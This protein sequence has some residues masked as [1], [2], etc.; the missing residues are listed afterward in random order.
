M[1]WWPTRAAEATPPVITL[2]TDYGSG[3]LYVGLLHGVIE[4]IAPGA[5]VIDLTHQLPLG[6][7]LGGALALA[8]ALPY[9]PVGIH[10]AV[11]DPGVGTDRRAVALRC[12]DGRILIGPDNGVLS[13]AVIAAGGVNAAVEISGSPLALDPVSA[14]FHGRDIFS[15]VAA[16]L[17]AGA[18]FIE[19]GVRLEPTDYVELEL[20]TAEVSEGTL[21]ATVTAV[22]SFGN[23]ALMARASEAQSAGLAPGSA[24]T[25]QSSGRK[26]HAR[27]GRTFADVG[28]GGLLLHEDS[29]G[30][31]ALA[32]NGGSAAATLGIG[33][34]DQVQL[35]R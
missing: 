18:S 3:G 34:G 26:L 27:Y 8:D 16:S 21:T 29:T 32:V 9:L 5:R 6:D 14:T 33:R 2:L 1:R 24:V 23:L 30:R 19:A 10:V 7:V 22:D 15:A 11:V 12:D 13:L 20:P 25:V 28:A 17:A 31:L 35:R 4:R